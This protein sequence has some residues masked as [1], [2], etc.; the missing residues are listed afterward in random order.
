MALKP[1]HGTACASI[2]PTVL[3]AEDEIL[4]RMTV[5]DAF[6]QAGYSVVEAAN[7]DEALTLLEAGVVVDLIFSDVQ[8]PGSMNGIDLLKVVKDRY[9]SISVI[10]TSGHTTPQVQELQGRYSFVPK[11]Y[12]PRVVLELAGQKIARRETRDEPERCTPRGH[13]L[14]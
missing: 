13:P 7:A 8:M 14:G 12:Q 3:I 9:P 1:I 5:V 2:A 4:V 6:L 11:P 10:L